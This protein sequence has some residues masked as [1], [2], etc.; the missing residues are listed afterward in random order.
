MKNTSSITLIKTISGGREDCQ[1]GR[2]TV[3][4]ASVAFVFA[5]LR[6]NGQTQVPLPTH[7]SR[8]QINSFLKGQSFITD[9]EPEIKTNQERK[10]LPLI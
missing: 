7:H 1:R 10:V 2:E 8:L 5:L 6:W 4:Q 3:L 9:E